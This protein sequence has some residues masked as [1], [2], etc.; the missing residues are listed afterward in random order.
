MLYLYCFIGF[1]CEND[2]V[3]VYTHTLERERGRE[4]LCIAASIYGF[5]RAVSFV[6]YRSISDYFV[7]YINHY[8]IQYNRRLT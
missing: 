5:A 4:S 7:R 2:I 6:V 1:K 8:Y 3:C